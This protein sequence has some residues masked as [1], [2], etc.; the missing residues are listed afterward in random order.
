MLNCHF[1]DYCMCFASL[2]I[3]LCTLASSGDMTA[4]QVDRDNNLQQ[5]P[6][7]YNMGDVKSRYEYICAEIGKFLFLCLH[8]LEK[9]YDTDFQ[10][11]FLQFFHTMLLELYHEVQ[12]SMSTSRSLRKL[13][14]HI[15]YTNTIY[16]IPIQYTIYQYNIPYTNTIYLIPYTIYNMPF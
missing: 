2:F 5:C 11:S 7:A 14:H 1:F 4:F 8:I 9:I 16:H 6:I 12:N 13:L 15:P 10:L 3:C